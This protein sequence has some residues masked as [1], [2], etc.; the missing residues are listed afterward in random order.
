MILQ[1]VFE[2]PNHLKLRSGY[3]ELFW[4]CETKKFRQKNVIFRSHAL[5]VSRPEISREVEGVTHEHFQYWEAKKTNGKSR[6]PLLSI[7]VFDVLKILKQRGFPQRTLWA[8]YVKKNSTEKSDITLLGMKFF[9]SRTFLIYRSVLQ[10]NPS[11][12]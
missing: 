6:C 1:K 3:H 8:V 9:D 10:R 5:K 2:I 12:L 4:Y 11:A 7:E